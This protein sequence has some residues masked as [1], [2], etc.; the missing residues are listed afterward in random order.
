[1][2]VHTRDSQRAIKDV[3]NSVR[4]ATT[5]NIVLSGAQTIDGVVLVVGDR[6][7]VK[8]QAVGAQNG[9][10]VVQA[11]A[12][13]RA[14]DAD[15]NDDLTSGCIVPVTEGT[16][17]GDKA[18]I[19]ATNDPITVGTT[20]LSWVETAAASI[21]AHEAAADPHTVY[22]KESE[23]GAA[24]GYAPLG[25]DSRVP[26]ANA[27][28]STNTN[29]D[30]GGQKVTNLGAP[31]SDND[32]AR[33]AY[34]DALVQGLDPKNSVRAATTGALPAHGRVGNVLTASANGAL[35]A[36]DGVALAV[37]D[38]V[39][40]KDEGGGSHL[41]NGIYAVTQ[42][43]DAGNP[44]ILTRA[45]DADMDIE[46][47]SGLFAFVSEGTV[48]ADSGWVLTTNDPIVLNTTA[49]TFTQF[50]GAGQI[51]AGAALTKTG[52]Q[53][54]VAVDNATIEV[55]ADALRVKD[56]GI[57]NA[58]VATGIGGDKVEAAAAGT[59]GTVLKAAAL[60]ATDPAA[61]GAHTNMDAPA[62]YTEGAMQTE[63]SKAD[64][65][66]NNLRT[67]LNQ[68]IDRRQELET[69][70]RTAGVLT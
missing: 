56:G 11:G 32:A 65:S 42:L 2:P 10:Y 51:V 28:A 9:I 7:L 61:V 24:N 53:L 15:S 66:I 17:N 43:G 36:Q 37:N 3:K 38:R 70:L 47:T 25:A 68:E 40:V 29:L 6:V 16:T 34:V 57:T 67:A 26:A 35:P 58:K 41:E 20:S 52:N 50:S 18:F 39:L 46:V 19:L 31:T 22:Q 14:Q 62:V 4:A 60:T 64:T 8:N 54:D 55:N 63:L 27:P 69:K 49:L 45:S 59:R 1:M 48:N 21:A 30:M 33:K 13:V 5:A 12:W 23:R 44:W